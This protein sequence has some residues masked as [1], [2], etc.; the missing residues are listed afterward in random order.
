VTMRTVRLAD[1]P[2]PVSA[3]GFGCASLGS[4]V[5][6]KVAAAAIERALAAGIN[7]FDVAP[8][9]GDG[10]AEEILGD[11]LGGQTVAIVTKVGLRARPANR[12]ARVARRFARPVVS[13]FPKLRTVI[14]PI[15]AQAIERIALDADSIHTSIARSLERLRVDRVAVLALHEPALEDLR[16]DEV[17]RALEDVKRQ[18]LAAH[19][20]IAGSFAS[21][22]VAND[23]RPFIDVAQ[24]E[25]SSSG[26]CGAEIR[27]VAARNAFA[28]MYGVFGAKGPEASRLSLRHAFG[29]NP[30]GVVLASS[31]APAHLAANVA[32]ASEMPDKVLAGEIERSLGSEGVPDNR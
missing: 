27:A 5:S 31:F 23:A 22:T 28:V 12:I 2:H 3:L 30:S 10:E 29:A 15:R 18:G 7:W 19:I 8:S 6:R 9:Y 13:A 4:R 26:R 25:L 14:R 32:A 1:W 17:L 11:T 21:F 16:R 24:F 20:G